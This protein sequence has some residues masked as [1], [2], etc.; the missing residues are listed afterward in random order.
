MNEWPPN[1]HICLQQSICLTEE[2]LD[3]GLEIG[4]DRY[5]IKGLVHHRG[6]GDWSVSVNRIGLGGWHILGKDSEPQRIPDR[7]A[8]LSRVVL[9][10]L[11]REN[12]Y[13]QDNATG[14]FLSQN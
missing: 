8:V 13:S 4:G 9:I 2:A 14:I 10:Q 1:L 5:S 6:E 12:Q 11:S 3:N 7:V